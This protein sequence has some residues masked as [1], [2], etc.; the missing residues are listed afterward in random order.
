MIGSYA[1]IMLYTLELVEAYTYY[2][3]SPRS[4]KDPIFLKGCVATSLVSDTVGTIAVCA[5]TFIVS[6]PNAIISFFLTCLKTNLVF[7]G[8]LLISIDWPLNTETSGRKILVPSW[9]GNSTGPSRRTLSAMQSVRLSS[10]VTWVIVTGYCESELASFFIVNV[11]ILK[12]FKIPQLRRFHLHRP[13][14]TRIGLSLSLKQP[15]P[16]LLIHFF[17][18]EQ[19]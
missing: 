3:A 18:L 4:S 14:D 7:T 2:F 1:N 8:M 11:L 5:L 10:S 12:L 19:T 6:A 15:W 17:S 13:P 16:F 9:R